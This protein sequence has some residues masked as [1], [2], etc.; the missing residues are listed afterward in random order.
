MAVA[1]GRAAEGSGSDELRK[2]PFS[3]SP[4]PPGTQVNH[5]TTPSNLDS[6]NMKSYSFRRIPT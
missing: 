2:G 6:Y 4:P 3:P 5:R 1:P